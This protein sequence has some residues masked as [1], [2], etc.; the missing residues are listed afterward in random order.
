MNKN[1][2]KLFISC[3]CIMTVFQLV[4]V[5]AETNEMETDVQ[6]VIET[7]E[8]EENIQ[9]VNATE[10]VEEEKL[11][12]NIYISD[13]D[14]LNDKLKY[15]KKK[16]EETKTIGYGKLTKIYDNNNPEGVVED[17]QYTKYAVS[18][19]YFLNMG[20][21]VNIRERPEFKAKI[22]TKKW[23]YQ[24]MNINALVEGEYS[25]KSDSNSW[26]R[27]F[28]EEDNKI[29]IGYVFSPVVEKREFQLDKMIKSANRLKEDVD[30]NQTAYIANYKNQHGWAPKYNGTSVDDYGVKREQSAPAYFGEFEDTGFRYMIDGTLLSVLS[31]TEEYF[32]VTAMGYEGL[33]FVPKKYVIFENSIESLDKIIIVDRNNQNEI[34]ME[35]I[36]G[37]WS[38]I[39][40]MFA[41][42]GVKATHKDE[43][44][45]GNFMVMARKSKFLYLDDI[46][47][48]ISGYAPFAVR[49]N[50]GAY[51]HGVPVNFKIVKETRIITPEVLDE[52]G[53]VSVPAVTEEVVVDRLD[54]GHSEFLSTIGTTPR[55]HKCVRNYTSH[56]KFLYDWT[57]VGK[58]AVIVIE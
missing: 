50:G 55:S 4:S 1:F 42:T 31:E 28:W 11:W 6:G 13:D 9:D 54:P 51:V 52:W 41:T 39:S 22:L 16:P 3:I 24:K 49:F 18:K 26:Y 57:E 25:N 12:E 23:R 35:H 32:K 34:V 40:K 45:L 27:V 56:A 21:V 58:T 29:K 10:E 2:R 30:N 47:E 33:Y 36:D 44:D 37:K 7:V 14:F 15:Q 20:A 43:T 5:Y 48:E 19:H 17:L 53:F 38:I 8:I 46:T